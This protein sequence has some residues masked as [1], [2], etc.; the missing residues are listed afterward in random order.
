MSNNLTFQISIPTDEGFL[1]RECNNPDCK[2]YFRVFV[3]SVEEELYCPYC[4]RKFSGSELW[5]PEQLRYAQQAA[6]EK[7][8]EYMFGEIDKMFGDLARR[9]RG[10]KNV[11]FKHKP[12]NYR[13]KHISPN[14]SEKQVDTELVCPEC[15]FRFQVFGIFGYCPKCRT[16]NLKIYDANLVII[17]QEI[18]NS[19]EPNR[20]LRHA[21][22][23]LV[24][25]FE[26][27]CRKKAASFT[28]ETTRF[29][30]ITDTRDFFK[31]HL[32]KN[33]FDG[34]SE[35]EQRI[36]RRVF[37]KRHLY[38][39]DGGIVNAKYVQI[40]PEDRKLLGQLAPLSEDEFRAAA[41][42]LRRVLNNLI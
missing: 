5:T 23:D 14:Y 24:S 20:A 27:F 22:S 6:I 34:I 2:K 38:E 25:T 12:T 11:I 40:I 3:E 26:Q 1:G 36:I 9:N 15:Q 41:D 4:G 17:L 28:Q 39:H 19:Q 18:A 35:D 16:E 13:A 31:K 33:I 7:A 37:Q 42:I 10:N 29:Q 30:N 21:Y 32:N 8:K